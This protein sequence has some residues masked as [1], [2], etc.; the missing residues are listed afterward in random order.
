MVTFLARTRP[1]LVH[2][3][4]QGRRAQ[5]LPDQGARA[6]PATD[7]ERWVRRQQRP[8]TPR[9]MERQPRR[10]LTPERRRD[11]RR[12]APRTCWA[13]L[14]SCA[15][16]KF[17]GLVEGELNGAAADPAGQ[18]VGQRGRGRPGLLWQTLRSLTSGDLHDGYTPAGGS[19]LRLP[20]VRFRSCLEPLPA[21]GDARD[22]AGQVCATRGPW[23]ADVRAT[24]RAPVPKPG[25]ASVLRQWNNWPM[26]TTGESRKDR[27]IR[28]SAGRAMSPH[29]T[30]AG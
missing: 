9:P 25:R 10:L 20:R 11:P 19:E 30:R 18:V 14:T 16:P 22:G 17:L 26:W 27:R 21:L 8:D 15:Q 28:S 24:A 6:A 7:V 3:A 4:T 13:S 1:G 12:T 5:R 29:L 2:R 23:A